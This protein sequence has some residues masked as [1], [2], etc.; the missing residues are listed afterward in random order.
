MTL[1][2]DLASLGGWP[3]RGSWYWDTNGWMDASE[4]AEPWNYIFCSDEL[5]EFC[6][7]LL[8]ISRYDTSLLRNTVLFV[9]LNAAIGNGEANEIDSYPAGRARLR[10]HL[11]PL[12]Q[13]HSF[14]AALIDGP[15]SGSYKREIISSVCKH[16][17]TAMMIIHTT[18][19]SLKQADEQASKGQLLQANLCYKAAL[20]FVRSCCWRYYEGDIIMNSGPFPGLTAKQNIDNI[21][22]RL[23]A[24]IAAVY[25][26]SGQLR[27]ARIYTERAID[28]CRPFDNRHNKVYKLSI[29]P[30]QGAVFAEVLH[31]AAKI[32][33]THGD[34]HEARNDLWDAG[35]LVPFDEEQQSR[36]EAWHIH[37]EDLLSRKAKQREARDLQSEQL[38][39][40]TEGIESS[41]EIFLSSE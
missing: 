36:Y 4:D 39:E 13:L 3:Q 2:L 5:P 28:P 6:R 41:D 35:Q 15:L 24:R 21:V 14:G 30:W 38:N 31:V 40:K 10:K 23:Q 1:T 7:L 22:V 16:C 11:G 8:K 12:H 33:Y 29:E 25:F 34:V 37:S 18:M 32:S 26:E 20:S 19:V 17:P 9:D 27:M